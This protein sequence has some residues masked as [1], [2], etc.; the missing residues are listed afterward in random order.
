M[1]KNFDETHSLL[2]RFLLAAFAS[3]I[4]ADGKA[5]ESTLAVPDKGALAV[6]W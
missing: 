4:V 1:F 6:S 2:Y 5:K 3:A